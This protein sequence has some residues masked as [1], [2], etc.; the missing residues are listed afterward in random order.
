MTSQDSAS[1]PLDSFGP[2]VCTRGDISLSVRVTVA[3]KQPVSPFTFDPHQSAC[4]MDRP[5]HGDTAITL[6][7]GLSHL[8]MPFLYLESAGHTILSTIIVTENWN[9]NIRTYTKNTQL[10]GS[11][12]K[13][14]MAASNH[15]SK[16][17]DVLCFTIYS[18]L[19][20]WMQRESL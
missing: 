2:S 15:T 3:S 14:H 17:N 9:L 4:L 11:L 1:V 12:K 20:Q 13:D 10:V 6:H 8:E 7:S 5:A 19:F 18:E 16:C